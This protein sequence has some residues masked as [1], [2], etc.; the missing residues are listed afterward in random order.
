MFASSV[1]PLTLLS[2][3]DRFS[4]NSIKK[5]SGENKGESRCWFNTK[6]SPNW[7]HKNCHRKENC[8]QDFKSETD[9]ECLTR[10]YGTKSW[11]ELLLWRKNYAQQFAKKCWCMKMK[12]CS[13]INK[14]LVNQFGLY[15]YKHWDIIVWLGWWQID[16]GRDT[17]KASTQQLFWFGAEKC[18]SLSMH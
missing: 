14:I 2:N 3:Q 18:G 6:N 11:F 9:K 8:L 17:L 5:N 4:P 15:F 10:S 13:N 12:H 1:H 16:L 7:Y